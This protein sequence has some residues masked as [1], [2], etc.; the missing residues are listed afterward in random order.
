[1]VTEP[2]SYYTQVHTLIN[3]Q[4]GAGMK[5]NVELRQRS[6]QDLTELNGA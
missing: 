2:V 4:Q 3:I 5:G 1:M 6:F